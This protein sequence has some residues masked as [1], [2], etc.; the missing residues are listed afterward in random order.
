MVG[1]TLLS[2]WRVDLRL[3]RIDLVHL[4]RK[5]LG[6]GRVE[7]EVILVVFEVL[8]RLAEGH[9]GRDTDAESDGEAEH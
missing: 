1:K 2:L 8:V 4:H 9:P 7:V 6:P 3:W 5:L